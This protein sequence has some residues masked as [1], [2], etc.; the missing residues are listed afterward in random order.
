MFAKGDKIVYPMYGAGVIEALEQREIDGDS[1]IFYVLR[2][3]VGNLKIMIAAGNAENLGIRHIYDKDEMIR[4]IKNV[5]QIPVDMPDNWNQRYK[6]NMEKIKSGR[7]SEVALVYRNLLLRE[8]E[9]GLSSAEKKMM[10]TAKQIIVS[11]LILSHNIEKSS[12]E[13]MLVGMFSEGVS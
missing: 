12:A 2:I 5:T 9:R 4:L 13:D 1:Q 6:S 3:P 10:T 7:L 11:E 8:R